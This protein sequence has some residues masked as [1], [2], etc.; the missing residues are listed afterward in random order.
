ML[1][2]FRVWK[3]EVC[4]R[5]CFKELEWRKI[6]SLLGKE[7]YPDPKA[8]TYVEEWEK[9]VQ[10]TLDELMKSESYRKEVEEDNRFWGKSL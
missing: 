4:D 6:L 2:D 8:G 9:K 3:G 5:N 1:T 7:Y 10:P